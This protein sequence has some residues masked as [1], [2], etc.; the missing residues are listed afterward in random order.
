MVSYRA[1]ETG[2]GLYS[3]VQG[4]LEWYGV[5]SIGLELYRLV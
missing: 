5:V 3:V 1:V 2:I 4:C